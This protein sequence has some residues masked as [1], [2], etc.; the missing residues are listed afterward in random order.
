MVLHERS[1]ESCIRAVGLHGVDTVHEVADTPTGG[2]E[3][4]C[5]PE[6]LRIVQDTTHVFL[7]GIVSHLIN[8]MKGILKNSYVEC[9]LT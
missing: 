1:E 3:G 7:R 4:L 9:E 6:V 8:F 5:H 2:L